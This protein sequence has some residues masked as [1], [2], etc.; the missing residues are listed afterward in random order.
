MRSLRAFG[1][2]GARPSHPELLDWL[3]TEFAE[4]GFSLK[5]MHELMVSS[6]TYQQSSQA[7]RQSSSDPD[8]KLL[9]R[10]NRQR[11]AAETIRDAV[12]NVAGTYTEQL[13]G[14]SVRVPLDPAV[15]DNI[16]TEGEPDNLWPVTPDARQHTRRTLYLLHKRNVRL[17]LLV[18]YDAPDLMSSCGARSVSVHALQSLTLMNSE[19]M[20][21]QAQSLSLRLAREAKTDAQRFA[22][23]YELTLGRKPAP[24]EMQLT[25]VFLREQQR[26]GRTSAQA[27]ADLCLAML[28]LNEF[29]YLD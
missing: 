20:W 12:L 23:L 1:K 13:Y 15:Y 22:R 27:W 29:I 26:L 3:A 5:Q 16:F 14:A 10:M 8:N 18:A 7:E 24:Q 6:N 17:P 11:L 21:Q 9:A 4:R 28:N 2:N 25:R 19:F